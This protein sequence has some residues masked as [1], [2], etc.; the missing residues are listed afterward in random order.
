MSF[1]RSMLMALAASVAFTSAAN[2]STIFLETT[3]AEAA[4]LP[5][6][7]G[8]QIVTF[9]SVVGGTYSSYTDG[10][11]TFS[12]DAVM[13]I[14]NQY[15]GVY[16]NFGVNS[17]HNIYNAP[18]FG[19]L[20]FTFT[21]PVSALGFFWGAA[22]EPW[23]LSAYDSADALIESYELPVLNGLNNGTFVGISASGIAYAT[24]TGSSGD[25]VFVDNVQT[26]P[27]PLPAALPLFSSAL[28]GLGGLARKRKAA[29]AV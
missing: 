10:N 27:V 2:A 22:D 25:W 16:N 20:T 15:M 21:S 17:L 19:K 24:I 18:S 4:A 1:V 12:A 26:S 9:D 3:P 28:I 7:A 8:G 14:D 5:E 13:Y 29:S 11:V 6:F 23:T